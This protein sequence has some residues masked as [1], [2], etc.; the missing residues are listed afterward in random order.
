MRRDDFRAISKCTGHITDELLGELAVMFLGRRR[1]SSG[2]NQCAA[3]CRPLHRTLRV[4]G[5]VALWTQ[6]ARGA[7]CVRSDTVRQ[8]CHTRG[9]ATCKALCDDLDCCGEYVPRATF[10]LD[11]ARM[12][13]ICLQLVTQA[14]YLHIDAAV[15]HLVAMQPRE[16][17]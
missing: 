2:A 15:V 3:D 11:I 13:Q 8:C 16:V 5:A 6:S 17:E 14:R 10:S 7:S 4:N 1:R 12:C 9:S